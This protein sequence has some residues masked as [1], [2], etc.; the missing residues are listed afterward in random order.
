MI[1][2]CSGG[3]WRVDGGLELY[4]TIYNMT[5]RYSI[6]T[7]PQLVDENVWSTSNISY[8]VLGNTVTG[9]GRIL[10]QCQ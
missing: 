6:D 5:Y 7:L 3:R 1:E 10:Y 4:P 2:K 8:S 9:T